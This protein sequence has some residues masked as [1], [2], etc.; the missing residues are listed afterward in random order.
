MAE[1]GRGLP[2]IGKIASQISRERYSGLNESIFMIPSRYGEPDEHLR[3][4]A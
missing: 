3:E 4:G 2:I 1:S